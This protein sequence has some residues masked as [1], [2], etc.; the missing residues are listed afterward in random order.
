[1]SDPSMDLLRLINGYWLS[2]AI[3]VAASLRIA[4]LLKDG[5]RTTEDLATAT[6]THRRSLYRLMRA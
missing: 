6:R 1:M 5:P 4:D 2:Q 3:S